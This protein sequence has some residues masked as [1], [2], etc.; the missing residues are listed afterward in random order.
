MSLGTSASVEE[1]KSFLVG[2]LLAIIYS[3]YEQRINK[4]IEKRVSRG[5]S[6]LQL[7]TFIREHYTRKGVGRIKVSDLG[8]TLAKFA[9]SYKKSFVSEVTDKPPHNAWDQLT[10]ARHGIAHMAGSNMTFEE[11]VQCYR[12]SVLVLSAF[13]RA[14]GLTPSEIGE[15]M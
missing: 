2:Y 13:A 1:I 11:L 8:E 15:W 4:I 12:S 5:G 10:S 9:Q 6:D 14:I 3:E 7:Q